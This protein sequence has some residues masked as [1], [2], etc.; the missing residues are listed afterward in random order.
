MRIAGSNYTATLEKIYNMNH[1]YFTFANDKGYLVFELELY[2]KG[3]KKILKVKMLSN[4]RQALYS[5]V[6]EGGFIFAYRHIFI[7]VAI[8]FFLSVVIFVYMKNNNIGLINKIN[9]ESPAGEGDEEEA[10]VD[11]G[12]EEEI[13]VNRDTGKQNTAVSF[14]R[15]IKLLI[16]FGCWFIV[17]LLMGLSEVSYGPPVIGLSFLFFI[18]YSI[19]LPITWLRTKFNKNTVDSKNQDAIS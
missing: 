3:L 19:Y 14:R 17:L 1:E 10:P 4:G 6:W 9:I 18:G 5:N 15:T 2:I 12:D 11:E 7:S 8:S 13:T 16:A